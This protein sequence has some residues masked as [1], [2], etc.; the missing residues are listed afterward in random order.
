MAHVVNPQVVSLEQS[1]RESLQK[2]TAESERRQKAVELQKE[3]WEKNRQVLSVQDSFVANKAATAAIAATK[4]EDDNK[5]KLEE[6]ILITTHA[7]EEAIEKRKLQVKEKV[8]LQM[9]RVTTEARKLDEL[10]REVDSLED[11][12]KK[13]VAEIRK[14]IESVDKELRPLQLLCAKREK[15][16]KEAVEAHNQKAKIKTELVMQLMEI[17]TKSEKI[18]MQKLDELNRHLEAMEKNGPNF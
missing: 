7:R 14:K 10:R 16:L 3:M 6:S 9:N 2:E 4:G 15:E 11:P 1:L 12:T 17:V 8:Q 18:R 13:E 5:Q